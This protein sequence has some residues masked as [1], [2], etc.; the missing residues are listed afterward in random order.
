MG[1]MNN[2][3]FTAAKLTFTNEIAIKLRTM[4]I[5]QAVIA[6]YQIEKGGSGRAFS[7]ENE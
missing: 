2:S 1:W 7:I 5:I 6:L 4:S 3:T